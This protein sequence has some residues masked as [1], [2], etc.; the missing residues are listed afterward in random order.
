MIFRG[1]FNK[2]I[3]N[4]REKNQ[5]RRAYDENDIRNIL[6]KNDVLAMIISAMLVILPAAI[7]VLVVVSLIGRFFVVRG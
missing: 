2:Q 1:R 3:Q 6:E 5:D 4:I 7:A